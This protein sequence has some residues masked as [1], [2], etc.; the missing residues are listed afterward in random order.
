MVAFLSREG[1]L[2]FVLP[3]FEVS[4]VSE[5]LGL[6]CHFF[7]YSDEEGP[8]SAF[9]LAGKN[10]GLS[11]ATIGIDYLHTRVLELRLIE[12]AARGCTVI[13]ARPIFAQLRSV[14]DA[15]EVRAMQQAVMITEVAIR[16]T[17]AQVQPGQTELDVQHILHREL[18]NAGAEDLAFTPI[19]VS[20][21]RSALQHAIS[22]DR[23]LQVG[24]L[25]LIDCGARFQHYT[26]DVTRTF[27]LGSVGTKLKEVYEVVVE[28][29]AAARGV[30]APGVP[31]QEVDRAARRVINRAGYGEFFVH[32]T[33]HGLGL[34][35]HE[36][37]Y[38]VEGNQ[39]LLRPGMTFTVEP[40]VYLPGLG[41]V[42]IEDDLLV[43]EEGHVSLTG[44]S[45]ELLEVL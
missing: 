6:E 18:I 41:G 33:G 15:A 5:R 12:I 22:T 1:E 43:T 16:Q 11:G 45:R 14:K 31:V 4:Q 24:D 36:A 40:G 2:A 28:A 27:A 32:R 38:V 17:V 7:P 34:E 42:R 39:E 26:S 44:Y 30:V 8:E 37:P 35:I 20:G 21:P 9:C 25:L 29:N 23:R 13:D 10:L 19:V 3:D